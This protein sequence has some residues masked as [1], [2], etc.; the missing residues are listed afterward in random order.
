MILRIPTIITIILSVT[1]LT[2]MTLRITTLSI[3]T[4]SI[5][6]HSFRTHTQHKWALSIT[7]KYQYSV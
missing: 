2:I 7:L 5:T 3:T 6:T 4:L 1:T